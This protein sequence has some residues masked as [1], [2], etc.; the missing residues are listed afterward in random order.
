[1]SLFLEMTCEEVVLSPG[2]QI[3]LLAKQHPDLLPLTI[4]LVEGG[5]QIHPH[6]VWDPEWLIRFGERVFKPAYPTKLLDLPG[7]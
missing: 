4:N 3:D 1:M 2:H 7:A 5:L 6:K